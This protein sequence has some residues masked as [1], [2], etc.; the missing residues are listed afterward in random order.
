[1][2]CLYSDNNLSYKGHVRQIIK[3]GLD[4]NLDWTLDSGL[5]TLDFGLW[6]LD[7]GIDSF[8]IINIINFEL[9]NFEL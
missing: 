6:L 3:D 9:F 1:M 2:N 7:S 5:W 4:C 8:I